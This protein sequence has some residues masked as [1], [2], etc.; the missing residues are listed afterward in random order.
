M[1][2]RLVIDGIGEGI[3]EP[4]RDISR[5]EFTVIAVKALGLMKPG[6]GKSIFKDVG[7]DAWY[8]DAVTIA[9]E[10]GIISG[11]DPNT[12][13]PQD[14]IT[15]EQAM[16]MIARVMKITGLK[17]VNNDEAASLLKSFADSDRASAWAGES[18]SAC[19]NAGIVAG[20]SVN[21]LAPQDNISRAE[22]AYIVCR[23]LQKSK[24]I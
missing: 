4:D 11:Y 8:Y 1:G 15:R 13:G 2:S 5:A 3:F 6:S 22:V 19:I 23:L 24:L 10:F 18:I 21:T 12:F 20:K 16:A 7:K 17:T 14:K 9:S